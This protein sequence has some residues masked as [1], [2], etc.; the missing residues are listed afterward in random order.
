MKNTIKEELLTVKFKAEEKKVNLY[1]VF[2][3]RD[4]ETEI[5]PNLK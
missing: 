5:Y 2:G 4:F 3:A 1:D